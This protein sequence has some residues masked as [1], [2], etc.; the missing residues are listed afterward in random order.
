ME[1]QRTS[2]GAMIVRSPEREKPQ[3]SINE[4]DLPAIKEWK[5]GE[6]Y[7]MT[8]NVEMTS[9]SKGNDYNVPLG[10]DGKRKETHNARFKILSIDS[11]P[12]RNLGEKKK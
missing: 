4:R 8:V 3:F 7:T 11:A 12:T 9:S 6:K 1:R 5:V 10:N 2:D